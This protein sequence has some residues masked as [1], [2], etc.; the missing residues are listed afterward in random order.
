[1]LWRGSIY[2]KAMCISIRSNVCTFEQRPSKSELNCTKI[3]QIAD[4]ITV[5]PWGYTEWPD[6]SMCS[7]I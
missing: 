1:M 4:Q 5:D 2:N 6:L 3:E 7:D